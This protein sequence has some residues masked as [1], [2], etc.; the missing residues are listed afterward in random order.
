MSRCLIVNCDDFGSTHAANEA[1]IT[2]LEEGAVTSATAMAPCNWFPEAAAY[3]HVNPEKSIGLHLTFTSE[4]QSLRWGPVSRGS[5]SSLMY[6]G[7]YFPQDTE[8]VEQRAL[9]REV[10]HEIH[11]QLAL[12]RT[13]GLNPSHLDNH[14]GSLCGLHGVQS[15]IPLVLRICAEEGLPFRLPSLFLRGDSLGDTLSDQVKASMGPMRE[16]ADSLQVP[17]LDCLLSHSYEKLPGETY[18]GFRDL[19]L[20]KMLRLP[21]GIHEIYLHPAMDCAELRAANPHWEK[22]TWEFQLFRDPAVKSALAGSDIRL[23]SWR[24]VR[25][26]RFSRKHGTVPHG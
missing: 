17:V 11:A 3:A 16:L 9:P 19:L 18:A 25:E 2:L 26:L 23:I 24:D 21:K 1:I 7:I 22:R 13:M 8:E 20:H 14:M 12:A 15:H 10:E 4:W 6:S 5:V